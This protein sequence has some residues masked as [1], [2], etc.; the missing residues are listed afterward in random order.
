MD[1]VRYKKS[2]FRSL[3]MVTQLGLSIVTPVFLCVFVGYQLDTRLGTKWMVPLLILGV[4]AGGRS[5]WLLTRRI[6][7]QEKKDDAILQ[8]E[9]QAKSTRTGT[10]RPKQPSRIRTEDHMTGKESDNDGMAQQKIK[11]TDS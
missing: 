9:K 4:L 7:E 10:S 11:E 1:T 2:V 6:L 3:A 8:Q 5:A